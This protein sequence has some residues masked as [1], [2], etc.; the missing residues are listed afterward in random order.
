[1][2]DKKVRPPSAALT[3]LTIRVRAPTRAV[4]HSPRIPAT[5]PR[6]LPPQGAETK[7]AE[8][9]SILKGLMSQPG[10]DDFLVFNDAG[11]TLEGQGVVEQHWRQHQWRL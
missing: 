4:S 7:D 11:E 3:A 2:A 5:A 1:M 10:V 9:E 8:V 6:F